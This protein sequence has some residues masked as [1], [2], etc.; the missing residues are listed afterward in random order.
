MTDTARNRGP[1]QHWR[2]SS[3]RQANKLSAVLLGVISQGEILVVNDRDII[4]SDKKC[5]NNY[6]SDLTRH[7][8]AHHD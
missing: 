1:H 2:K 5:L 4:I 8:R 7:W 6:V 3:S